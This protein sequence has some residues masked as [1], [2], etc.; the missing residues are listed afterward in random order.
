[1]LTAHNLVFVRF[2]CSHRSVFNE[3]SERILSHH[4]FIVYTFDGF[5]RIA[6]NLLWRATGDI[7]NQ[8]IIRIFRT[9]DKPHIFRAHPGL[10][11]MSKTAFSGSEVYA[12]KRRF[13][14]FV[15]CFRPNNNLRISD[16][17]IVHRV[18]S[19]FHFHLPALFLC[20]DQML[21]L[22]WS[23]AIFLKRSLKFVE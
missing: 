4:S 13:R 12:N 3:V 8:N 1:M 9:I 15:H 21:E 22:P 2:S 6:S 7:S 18:L 5:T 10:F 19:I 11:T 14:Q 23:W 20:L 16:N 17:T